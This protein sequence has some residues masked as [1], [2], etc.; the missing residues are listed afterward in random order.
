MHGT[1]SGMCTVRLRG[2]ILYPVTK[3]ATHRPIRRRRLGKRLE[4]LREAMGFTQEQAAEALGLNKGTVSRYEAAVTKISVAHT[5]AMCDTYGVDPKTK[6]HLIELARRADV[7]GWWNQYGGATA[8]WFLDYLALEADTAVLSNYE[9]ELIPGLFQ[10]GEYAAEV[11]ARMWPTSQPDE[12]GIRRR[13]DLRLDRQKAAFERP[14]PLTMWA[15]ISEGALRRVVGGPQIMVAQLEHVLELAERPNIIVQVMPFERGA[16]AGMLSPFVLLEF[17]DPDI[18]PGVV[19]LEQRTSSL[20][21]EG[22][23]DVTAYT[24]AI[25]HLRAGSLDPDQSVGLIRAI[26]SDLARSDR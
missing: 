4:E 9:S 12:E 22:A 14:R 18:D 20:Y 24:L 2:A 7:R 11:T 13:V 17:P 16:H 5:I 8:E 3:K 10:T 21:L 25:E 6:A 15:F 1:D 23:S 19:Y 26:A